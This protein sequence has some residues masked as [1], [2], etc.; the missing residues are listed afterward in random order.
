MVSDILKCTIPLLRISENPPGPNYWYLYALIDWLAWLAIGFWNF[1]PQGKS[2]LSM[3][4]PIRMTLVALWQNRMATCTETALC[5]LK[6]QLNFWNKTKM[7]MVCMIQIYCAKVKPCH[8]L[9]LKWIHGAKCMQDCVFLLRFLANLFTDQV[10]GHGGLSESSLRKLVLYIPGEELI[11]EEI[12]SNYCWPI[13]TKKS[14]WNCKNVETSIGFRNFN[15]SCIAT[16]QKNPSCRSS[17]RH[18]K[19]GMSWAST[20][21]IKFSTG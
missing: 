15:H 8:F 13:G 6:F 9:N 17:R 14:F 4:E 12:S 11:F 19:S 10:A 18:S 7:V 20:A 21:L 16:S 2:F 3:L 1:L 5:A